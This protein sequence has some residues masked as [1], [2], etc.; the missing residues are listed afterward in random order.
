MCRVM[1]A[2]HS[3]GAT[4]VDRTRGCLIRWGMKL[5]L[6]GGLCVCVCVCVRARVCARVCVCACVSHFIHLPFYFYLCQTGRWSTCSVSNLSSLQTK[7]SAP[8]CLLFSVRCLTTLASSMQ[9]SPSWD[10][11]RCATFSDYPSYS[12][13]RPTLVP[14]L[15]KFSPVLIY[16]RWFKYDRD[17]L[18]VNKSQFVLVIFEP[19]CTSHFFQFL[20]DI[21]ILSSLDF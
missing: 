5:E 12:T 17:W 7:T 21:I 6:T 10:A 4:T 8:A 2:R 15:N 14:V 16:T 20:I 18:C 3:A 13:D 9:Q 11:N 19:P 1:H